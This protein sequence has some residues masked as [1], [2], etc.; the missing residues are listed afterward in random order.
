MPLISSRLRKASASSGASNG[1]LNPGSLKD[2]QSVRFALLTEDAFDFYQFWVK[3]K[4]GEGRKPIRCVDEPSPEDVDQLIAEANERYD[5]EYI[6]PLTKDGKG[7]EPIKP[8]AAIAVYNFET[9]SVQIFDW[10]QSTITQ[11]LDELSQMEDYENSMTEIDL[12]LKRTGQGMD[13]RYGLN[14]VPRKKGT[15]ASIEAA[16]EDAQAKGFDIERLIG[17]GNP[18]EDSSDD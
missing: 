15:T 11:A 13:T 17:G 12:V 6:R 9:G 4:D 8:A 14:A 7:K 10:Y 2:G 16:W 18:F 5:N 1:F 3:E